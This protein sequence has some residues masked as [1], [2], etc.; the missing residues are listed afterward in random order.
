MN[1]KRKYEHLKQLSYSNYINNQEKE[2]DHQNKKMCTNTV[3]SSD[4]FV[5]SVC[6]PANIKSNISKKDQKQIY[7][8]LKGIFEQLYGKNNYILLEH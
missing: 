3:M 5:K 6:V 7:F 8:Y 2:N 1:I 4:N